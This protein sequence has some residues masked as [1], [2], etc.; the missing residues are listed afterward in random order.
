MKWLITICTALIIAVPTQAQLV[1][2]G[3]E[4]GDLTGWTW[5]PPP[6]GGGSAGAVTSHTDTGPWNVTPVTI[7]PGVTS[8][9]PNEG[10]YFGLLKTNGPGSVA[11]LYQSFTVPAGA[12]LSFDYF[13]DSQDYVSSY[14]CFDDNAVGAVLQGAG[15][16]GAIETI[17]FTESVYQDMADHGSNYWGTEWTPVSYT[18]PAAGT[19]TLVLDI[20]NICDSVLDSHVGIDAAA[21]DGGYVQ[22]DIK[23]GSC[24]NPLNPK[25]KGVVP[26][27][28]VA[29]EDF[30]PTTVDVG[31]ILLNG[32]VVPV[33]AEMIDSTQPGDYD[34]ADCYDC[35]N[36]EDH[37]NADLWIGDPEDGVPGQ[38][39]DPDTYI[40]D[41]MYDLV[42][43][44]DTQ[45]LVDSIGSAAKGACLELTLTGETE[46]GGAI[47]GSDSVV[48]LKAIN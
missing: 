36:E 5:A 31:S 9:G 41:C 3:F 48:V 35:F 21:I 19:Y 38:D 40:G 28:I 4:T 16:G 25:S 32:D 2:G 27:A 46:T 43:Y 14:P 10:T 23:P 11:Y 39:G 30:D 17:L 45:E 1:N 15:L 29:T 34:P 24:P 12:V 33:N 22:V 42:L 6:G 7:P 37:Y 44:F 18:L 26:V 20:E 13:W 8:W 47:E